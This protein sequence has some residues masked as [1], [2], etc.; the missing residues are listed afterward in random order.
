MVAMEDGILSVMSVGDGSLLGVRAEP[1]RDISVV[2]YHMA[3]SAGRAG[4]VLTPR[5]PHRTAHLDGTGTVIHRCSARGRSSGEA[6]K[7]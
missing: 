2:A 4:H 5:A 1:G 3:L 6:G 7:R